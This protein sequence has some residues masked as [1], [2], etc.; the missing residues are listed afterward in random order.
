MKNRCKSILIL[1][2]IG[3]IHFTS[4][5]QR[6]EQVNEQVNEARELNGQ[7]NYTGAIAKYNEA[8]KADPENINANIGI[9]Y[10]LYALDRGLEAIPYLERAIKSGDVL[11]PGIYDLMGSIYDRANQPEKSIAAYKEGIKIK[12]ELQ[13]LHYDLGLAYFRNKQYVEAE[14][15][16]IEA[17]KLDPKHANSQRLYA[18]VTFHQNKRVNA[19]LGFCSFL[20]LQPQ[21]SRPAEAYGNI[22]H[23]LQG[24]VLK[25]EEGAT[26]LPPA[27][28][29]E[30]AVLN[31]RIASV[32][33]AGKAKKLTGLNLLEYE[34]KNIFITAGQLA[35]K[36]TDK[37]F[38]DKF[39]AAY[40][41]KLAQSDN[42][43]A[44]T[45]LVTLTVNKEESDQW[46]R[47]NMPKV[48]AFNDWIEK[49]ER[50]F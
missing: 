33:A 24:G 10:S 23:I 15:S 4:L 14:A 41:Y 39:F 50:A 46:K 35:E 21:S 26:P 27:E 30:I 34:F 12:P 5:A 40:F 44:F 47:E 22:M 43:L 25:P 29:K 17:I 3:F 36:K 19:L 20:L 16:A 2:M 45:R 8:L 48:N 32:A 9:A 28:A 6:K 49:T 18:L 7:R 37:S 38:F 42:M 31:A 13:G 1:L 11:D